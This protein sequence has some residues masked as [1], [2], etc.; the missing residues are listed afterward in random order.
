MLQSN[1]NPKY[2]IIFLEVHHIKLPFSALSTI[3]ISNLFSLIKITFKP[4]D[5]TYT[6]T[7]E[8]FK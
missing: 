6:V 1:K 5:S 7:I 2:W 3:G 8:N 4:T